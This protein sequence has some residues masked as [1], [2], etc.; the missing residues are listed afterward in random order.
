MLS[1]LGPGV[2][3]WPGGPPTSSPGWPRGGIRPWRSSAW[4]QGL[5]LLVISVVVAVRWDTVTWSGWPLWAVAAGL[6]GMAGLV[7]FYSALSAGT[8]GVVAPIA[9]LGVVVPVV[10]GVATGEEPSP[11]AWVGMLVAIV[12]GDAGLAVPS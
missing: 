9:A 12:G 6:A 10:L 5:A 11:W 7:C 4:T 1:V 2:A 8:M 3:P